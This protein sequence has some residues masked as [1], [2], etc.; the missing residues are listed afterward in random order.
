VESESAKEIKELRDANTQ[1][2]WLKKDVRCV[3]FPRIDEL[4][5]PGNV[6]V[7]KRAGDI[8]PKKAKKK[9]KVNCVCQLNC[10]CVKCKCTKNGNCTAHIC[11]VCNQL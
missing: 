3:S 2:S 4:N 10:K 7:K 5:L 9:P 11:F 1:K 8:L 6:K